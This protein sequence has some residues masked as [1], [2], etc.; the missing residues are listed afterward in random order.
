MQKLRS[1]LKVGSSGALITDQYGSE[2][3]VSLELMFGTAVTLEF[4]MR[5]GNAVGTDDV[6]P[7]IPLADLTAQSYYFAI[8]RTNSNAT[9][10]ALLRYSDISCAADK[11][12]CSIITVPLPFTAT[13]KLK[14]LMQNSAS[15]ECKA[16]IGG[17]DADGRT[18]FAWQFTLTLHSRV[19]IGEADESI[20]TDPLYYTA[21]QIEALIGKELFYEYSSD[22]E[23]NWHLQLQS[24]DCWFRVRHGIA[25]IASAPQLIPYGPRGANG[26][27]AYIGQIIACAGENIPSGFLPCS[28]A[29]VSRS[30]YAE[31]FAVIGT[32]Y[33]AGDGTS[34]FALPDLRGK[35]IQGAGIDAAG[36]VK[37]AG[38]P[39]IQGF[40][41][42]GASNYYVPVVSTGGAFVAGNTE[43]KAFLASTEIVSRSDI[44]MLNFN[45]GSSNAIYGASSTVQPPAVVVNYAIKY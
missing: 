31:L 5:G 27:D 20:L 30:T 9:E 28:G 44:G 42:V 43:T 3:G 29:L 15:A 25:G 12:G 23:S 35:V 34:S 11:D 17:I 2:K 22:G 8:D 18:L 39:N 10:P 33:G 19:Y 16:E 38:L 26:S 36:T 32:T 21:A 24:G 40:F 4:D 13:E 37:A 7:V 41:R 14:T 45:A 1:I 6:L